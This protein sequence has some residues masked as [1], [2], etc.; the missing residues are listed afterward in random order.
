MGPGI[1]ILFI[2]AVWA[3]VLIIRVQSIFGQKFLLISGDNILNAKGIAL[4]NGAYLFLW[5]IAI[6]G[7]CLGLWNPASATHG[8]KAIAGR[9]EPIHHKE[10]SRCPGDLPHCPR[11]R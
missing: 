7:F 3:L 9:Q 2:S 1:T 6:G 4:S 8:N 10:Q 5:F 11:R